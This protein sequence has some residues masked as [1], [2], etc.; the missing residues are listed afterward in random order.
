GPFLVPLTGQFDGVGGLPF[1]LE[2]TE[3][4]G[5]G[6]PGP[7]FDP[8]VLQAPPPGIGFYVHG[9]SPISRIDDLAL[10]A[11]RETANP[12]ADAVNLS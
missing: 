6:A 2:R 1:G 11:S 7:M 9:V 12:S 4:I 10:Q 5:V 3:A 8:A